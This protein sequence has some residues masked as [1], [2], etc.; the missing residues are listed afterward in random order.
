MPFQPLWSYSNLLYLAVVSREKILT[1]N[2]DKERNE[3]KIAGKLQLSTR[4]AWAIANIEYNI[5][6]VQKDT[7]LEKHL[8]RNH[9]GA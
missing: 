7:G 5:Y 4:N 6:P 2:L 8:N 9:G 3:V 1:E